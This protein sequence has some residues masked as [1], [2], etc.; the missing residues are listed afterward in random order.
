MA[1]VT[2]KITVYNIV[3]ENRRS[4]SVQAGHRNPKSKSV[5]VKRCLECTLE[6]V[7]DKLQKGGA[8][9]VRES[10]LYSLFFKSLRNRRICSS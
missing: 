6:H 10:C 1:M 7:W 2:I 3:Q 8:E 9:V 4:V 5:K